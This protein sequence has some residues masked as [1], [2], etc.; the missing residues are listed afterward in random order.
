MTT[1]EDLSNEIIYEIFGYV[2][3]QQLFEIFYDLNERFRNFLIRSNLPIDINISSMTKRNFIRYFT[4]MIV[5]HVHRIRSLQICTPFA[6][7]I[8]LLLSP[9]IN[10]INR[11]ERLVIDGIGIKSIEEILHHLTSLSTL[12]SLTIT[13]TDDNRISNDI[14]RKIFRLSTLKYCR[15]RIK[16]K[17]YER[18][19]SLATNQFSSIEHLVIDSE[20][21]SSELNALLSYVPLLR[22]LSLGF[23]TGRPYNIIEK[24]RSTVDQLTD[25][26]L[27]LHGI[28]F[29]DFEIL[30]R[31]FFRSIQ[32]L[33]FTSVATFY[34]TPEMEYIHADRWQQLIAIHMPNLRVFDFHHQQ[35]SYNRPIDRQLYEI[36]IVKFN[37]LFW[38]EHHWFF[39]YQSAQ[40]AP[41]NYA[42]LYSINPYR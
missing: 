11:L 24:K 4:Q 27:R 13:S 28:R 3:F 12:S 15:I 17:R 40:T 1:L 23:L 18:P 25:V 8:Y 10:N 9:K 37:S 32:N 36:E 6:D 38:S 7:K 26:S 16:T 34:S 20:V 33:R 29:N 2:D 30:V 42:L 5:P 22:R 35:C 14:Y 21:M 31:C 39:Q 19:L 41:F